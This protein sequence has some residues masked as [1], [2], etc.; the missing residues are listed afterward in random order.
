[1][2]CCPNFVAHWEEQRS[3]GE[4]NED[5]VSIS[6]HSPNGEAGV[7]V[8]NV[9]DHHTCDG[10]SQ[11]SDCYLFFFAG[12]VDIIGGDLASFFGFALAFFL[13][14]LCELLPFAMM[15]TSVRKREVAAR[16]GFAGMASLSR[17]LVNARSLAHTS[18]TARGV[19]FAPTLPGV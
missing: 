8:G 7:V 4:S 1:M 16:S 5:G 10:E 15:L 14:L 18:E 2:F 3:S 13:S 11:L 17:L 12:R 9:G 6:R 19:G